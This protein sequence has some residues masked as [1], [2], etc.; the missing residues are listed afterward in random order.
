MISRTSIPR[1]ATA[2]ALLA[3]LVAAPAAGEPGFEEVWRDG[4]AELA[5]YRYT[6]TRYGA[7]RE[8]QAVAIFVTEP[9]SDR[10]RVKVDDPSRNPRDTFEALKLNLVRDFQTGIY[11]YNTMTSVFVRASDFV[12]AKISFSSAD[13]CGHVYEEVRFDR[14]ALRHSLRSYFEGETVDQTLPP[15]RGGVTEDAL[16]ILLRGLRGPYLGPDV[17]RVVPFLPSA[18][19]RRVTHRSLA[20]STATIERSG[21]VEKVR[22]PAGSFEAIRYVVRPRD[23]REG[24]FWI[25]AAA[26]HRL[27]RWTWT[28]APVGSRMAADGSEIAELTGSGRLPYWELNANGDEAILAKLGLRPLPGRNTK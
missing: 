7:P 28:G 18:F 2:L 13:W 24:T 27:L 21:A 17:K 22:V 14:D 25:E 16:P 20:W 3:T 15:E 26:P 19:T 6:V 9:F 8:G 10:D 5:G 4:R 12:P 23:G 11:D 1:A